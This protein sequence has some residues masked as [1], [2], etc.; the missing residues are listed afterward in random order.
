M[1]PMHPIFLLHYKIP[2]VAAVVTLGQA[3]TDGKQNC[4]ISNEFKNGY[5]TI[6][7]NMV[8]YFYI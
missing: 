2:I 4:A 8:S 5:F 1:L 7:N 6:Y 3:F